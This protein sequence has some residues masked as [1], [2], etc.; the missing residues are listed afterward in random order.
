MIYE[1]PFFKLNIMKNISYVLILSLF[2]CVSCTKDEQLQDDP[3]IYQN[4]TTKNQLG[5]VEVC[6]F[7]KSENI[8]EVININENSL[9]SHLNH[10]DVVLI[11]ADG[12]GFVEDLN[13]CVPGGDCDDS[14]PTIYPGAIEI[15]GDGIDQDCDGFDEPCNLLWPSELIGTWIGP[16]NFGHTVTIVLDNNGDS[17]Y[18]IDFGSFTCLFNLLL[19]DDLGGGTFTGDI[20]PIPGGCATFSNFTMIIQGDIMDWQLGGSNYATLQKQ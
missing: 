10:G 19:T 11:D 17:T 3:S 12:D 7:A 5:K 16:N 1:E 20:I 14:D 15:C 2:V 18:F 9:N 6:H 13:E 4:A 8:W